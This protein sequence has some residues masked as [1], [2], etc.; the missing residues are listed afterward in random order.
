MKTTTGEGPPH[1]RLMLRS[2]R[3]EQER[4]V[5]VHGRKVTMSVLA[6][7]EALS[8]RSPNNT[9]LTFCLLAQTTTDEKDYLLSPCRLVARHDN[10]HSYIH[11]GTVVTVLY[12]SIQEKCHVDS[13]KTTMVVLSL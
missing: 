5:A 6:V 10:T 13:I 3:H 8:V 2:G 4:F 9:T 1:L 7:G 11:L 12:T